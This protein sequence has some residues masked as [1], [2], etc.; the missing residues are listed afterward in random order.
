EEVLAGI[1]ARVLG[2]ERVG[3]DDS[4]FELGGDSLSAMRLVA[5]INT[6]LDAGLAVRTLFHAPSVRSLSQQLGRHASEVEVVPVEILKKGTGV[7]L[8]CVHPGSGVS[9]PYQALGNYLDC[10]IIGIQRIRQSEEAEPRSIRDMAKDYADR[11]QGA[12]PTGPYN[13]LGWSFGGVVAHELA[14]ELQ[15]RGCEIARL[16]L[17]DAQPSID[18][19]VTLP[20]HALVEN[21]ALEEVLRFYR[22][23]IPEQDGPLTYE[24]VEELVRERGAVEFSQYKQLFDLGVHNLNSSFALHRA[25]EPGVFDGDVIIFSALPDEKFRSSPPLESWR[26]YVAGHITEYWIDCR[27]EDMLTA[28]SLSLYGQQLKF[29]L[30]A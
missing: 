2:L 22:V 28:E 6:T 29:S 26:L 8:F 20:S 13:L 17:L 16:I 4:F 24:Q 18:S 7:P 14:V 12:Y 30:K 1:Y 5:A 11:I 23:D 10:P 27:H 21:Q 3:V 19:N 9:W 15:R 25:H